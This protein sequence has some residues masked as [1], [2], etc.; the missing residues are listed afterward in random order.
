[1]Y[2]SNNKLKEQGILTE[3]SSLARSLSE[4]ESGLTSNGVNNTSLM[5]ENFEA[6]SAFTT[7]ML[8]N[9]NTIDGGLAAL[10]KL[11]AELINSLQG[12]SSA[13]G[14]AGIF[15]GI[16]GTILG[17]PAGTILGTVLG[18]LG[19]LTSPR[20]LNNPSVDAVFRSSREQ[21]AGSSA[22]GGIINQIIIKNPVTF[23]RAFD[24]EVRTRSA[25]GGIDL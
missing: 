25:R 6:M 24:V 23:Q 16:I 4:A 19:G 14:I 22:G 17:G 2:T 20:S 3:L 8:A 10:L 15:G 12:G 9:M 21:T 18:G 7:K 5:L 13:G 11:F 1:M